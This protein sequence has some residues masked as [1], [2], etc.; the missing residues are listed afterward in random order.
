[1]DGVGGNRQLIPGSNP[2]WLDMFSPEYNIAAYMGWDTSAR[3][4]KTPMSRQASF[5]PGDLNQSD[6]LAAI[7][8]S[9]TSRSDTFIIRA[10]GESVHP[11]SGRAEAQAWCEA[12]V[13]R[14][15][16]YV[17][18]QADAAGTAGADLTSVENRQFGRRF[19]VIAFRWLNP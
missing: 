5:A 13:Q 4:N 11:Q 3:K 1:V 14:I 6:I 2:N 19:R 8:A 7:G 15:P 9:L 12:V 17:N 18:S 10:Y 16:E